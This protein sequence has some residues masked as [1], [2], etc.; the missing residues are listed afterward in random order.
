MQSESSDTGSYTDAESD[1]ESRISL[2]PSRSLTNSPIPVRVFLPME[3]D[4]ENG[5]IIQVRL[6]IFKLNG[7]KAV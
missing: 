4:L 2:S 7:N 1:Q 3:V 5:Q 6:E